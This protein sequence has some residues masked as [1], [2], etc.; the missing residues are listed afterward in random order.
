MRRCRPSSIRIL[1]FLLASQLAASVAS[2]TDV[3][4][5]VGTLQAAIDAASPG[6]DLVLTGGTYVGPVVVNKPLRLSCVS[7]L[8]CFLDAN[9]EAPVALDIAA[10]HVRVQSRGKIANFSVLRGATTQIRIADHRQVELRTRIVAT[11][12]EESPCGTEQT[13]IEVS[14][15]S[16]NVKLVGTLSYDSPRAGILLSGLGL[17]ARVQI[18]KC[19]GIDNG[20][21]IAIEHSASGAK[22][23]AAGIVIDHATLVA[24][25][26]AVDVVDSDGIR[27]KRST[28]RAGDASPPV[29]GVSFDGTSDG[30]R[31]VKCDSD[32]APQTLEFPDAGTNNCGQHNL[33]VALTPCSQL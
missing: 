14:G 4:A 17:D 23:G 16:S 2:A 30:N 22:P 1:G 7:P 21:G 13:G 10:D 33:N 12:S 27:I 5:G 9:C 19:L 24:N 6:D 28:F 3:P 20:A 25:G 29:T 15:T 8:S 31:V 26:I 18:K 11:V 32:P